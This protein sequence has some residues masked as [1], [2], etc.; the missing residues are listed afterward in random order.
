MEEEEVIMGRVIIYR[1]MINDQRDHLTC[2][3]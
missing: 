3:G 1:T 2:S